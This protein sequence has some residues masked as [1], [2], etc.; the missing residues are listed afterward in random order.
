MT[1]KGHINKCPV[2]GQLLQLARRFV[3]RCAH[4]LS[5]AARLLRDAAAQ[6]RGL[7]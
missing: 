2:I 3:R 6:R 4:L 1:E 5:S 7:N